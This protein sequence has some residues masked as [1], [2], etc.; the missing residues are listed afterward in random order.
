MWMSR[1]FFFLSGISPIK[2]EKLVSQ[3]KKFAKKYFHSFVLNLLLAELMQFRLAAITERASR[4]SPAMS[5]I[6]PKADIGWGEPV[7]H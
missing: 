7:D 2:T 5:A 6:T 3:Q 4:L 1:N